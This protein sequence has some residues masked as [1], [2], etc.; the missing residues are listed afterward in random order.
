MPAPHRLIGHLLYDTGFWLSEIAHQCA[1]HKALDRESSVSVFSFTVNWI[2]P[3][4][5]FSH[6]LNLL[7]KSRYC[8][9]I[10]LPAI[11]SLYYIPLFVLISTHTDKKKSWQFRHA[12]RIS[13]YWYY[14]NVLIIMYGNTVSIIMTLC[15]A[16]DFTVKKKNYIQITICIFIFGWLCYGSHAEL[17]THPWGTGTMNIFLKNGGCGRTVINYYK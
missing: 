14:A 9:C 11:S 7:L 5:I 10:I 15:P 3:K 6:S 2:N 8:F 16:S 12:E 4:I 17:R 1:T 13:C